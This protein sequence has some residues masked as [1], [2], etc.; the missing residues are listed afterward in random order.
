MDELCAE[1]DRNATTSST[2]S[3]NTT[4]RLSSL[5][6]PL[7]WSRRNI[8]EITTTP[9]VMRR[10]TTRKGPAARKCNR[11]TGNLHRPPSI[12]PSSSVFFLS[13]S[14]E[15][16]SGRTSATVDVEYPNSL[17]HEEQRLLKLQQHQQ[18]QPVLISSLQRRQIT[19]PQTP[20]IP[21]Q[22]GPFAGIRPQLLP[23]QLSPMAL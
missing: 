10:N 19:A 12:S 20:Q 22:F 3:L 5:F 17:S 2:Q 15:D 7:R 23:S 4:K 14:G 13:P 21:R 18:P 9:Q 6:N 16:A 11:S 1:R 8:N